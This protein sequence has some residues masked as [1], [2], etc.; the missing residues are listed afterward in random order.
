MAVLGRSLLECG[1]IRFHQQRKYVLDI[2]RLLL[3]VEQ[4]EV[5]DQLEEPAFS[6]AVKAYIS[7]RLFSHSD[8]LAQRCLE[9][10]G[11]IKSWLA[12]IADKIAAAQALGQSISAS[13][14]LETVEY[15]RLSL[16]QQHET[17]GVILC[18]AVEQRQAEVQDFRMLLDSLKR[19]DKYDALLGELDYLPR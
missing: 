14:E 3:D 5:D 16:L 12:R 13:A 15:S 8:R 9:S 1:L 17:L 10:M 7:E 6:D 2:L 4:L 18:R 19:A 11:H